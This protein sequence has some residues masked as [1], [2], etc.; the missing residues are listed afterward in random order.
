MIAFFFCIDV[1]YVFASDYVWLYEE[2]GGCP[3]SSALFHYYFY[4]FGLDIFIQHI[5]GSIRWPW[6]PKY[7]GLLAF[8]GPFAN[9]FCEYAVGYFKLHSVALCMY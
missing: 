9:V 1:L 7:V 4:S 6:I 5:C 8:Y 3:P 2:E